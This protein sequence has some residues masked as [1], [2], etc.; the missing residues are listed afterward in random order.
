MQQSIFQ[1]GQLDGLSISNNHLPLPWVEEDIPHLENIQPSA[2]TIHEHLSQIL[3]FARKIA[4]LTGLQMH[5]S[6]PTW[7]AS[8]ILGSLVNGISNKIG[9]TISERNARQRSIPACITARSTTIM[10][11]INSLQVFNPASALKVST[12]SKSR[13]RKPYTQMRLVS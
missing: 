3:T 7:Q 12:A 8:G 5:S 4:G 11:G 13:S 1:V 6:T 2:S 10:S 9:A